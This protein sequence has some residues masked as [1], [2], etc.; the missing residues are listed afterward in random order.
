VSKST[1]L[2]MYGYVQSATTERPNGQHGPVVFCSGQG[3]QKNAPVEN[4]DVFQ[5]ARS[6]CLVGGAQSILV[7]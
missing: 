4:S 6:V 7:K 2:L 1:K 3:C 5:V